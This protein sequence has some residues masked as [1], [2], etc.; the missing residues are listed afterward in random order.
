[1]EQQYISSL[2]DAYGKGYEKRNKDMT[3]APGRKDH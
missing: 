2:L 3:D 1:M